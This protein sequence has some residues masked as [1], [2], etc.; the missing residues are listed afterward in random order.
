M[1]AFLIA[2]FCLL[3]QTDAKEDK[4]NSIQSRQG[5]EVKIESLE[6]SRFNGELTSNLGKTGELVPKIERA[7]VL[8]ISITGTDH[9]A[10][11]RIRLANGTLIDVKILG[12]TLRRGVQGIKGAEGTEE[13]WFEIDKA[14][15]LDEIFPCSVLAR[16]KSADG[17]WINFEF[18]QITP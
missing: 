5:I 10:A 1:S 7:V 11:P 15:S 4:A 6:L 12:N 17:N 18:K 3:P 8:T 13:S 14:L 16:A 2:V 9:T